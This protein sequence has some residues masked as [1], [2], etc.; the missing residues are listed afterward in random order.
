MQTAT[1][2]TAGCGNEGHP[3]PLD[4]IDPDTPVDAVL[5]GACGAVITDVADA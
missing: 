2:R 4:F 5:C 3:V 1:C